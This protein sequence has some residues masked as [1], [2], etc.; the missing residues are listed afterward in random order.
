MHCINVLLQKCTM[1]HWNLASYVRNFQKVLVKVTLYAIRITRPRTVPE[2][3]GVSD[4]PSYVCLH[5]YT[6][7]CFVSADS[8]ANTWIPYYTL[9]RGGVTVCLVLTVDAQPFSSAYCRQLCHFCKVHTIQCIKIL[10]LRCNLTQILFP[11]VCLP[12]PPLEPTQIYR[13]LKGRHSLKV[14][15]HVKYW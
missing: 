13:F 4:S 12:S 3:D 2:N 9:S 5:S 8:L 15:P 11:R 6:V 14:K 10:L 7:Q 1:I